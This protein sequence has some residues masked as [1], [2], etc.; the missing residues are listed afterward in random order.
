MPKGKYHFSSTN[1]TAALAQRP[2]QAPKP[3]ASS[4]TWY[5]G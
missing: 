2:A 1:T 3:R 5:V 4:H